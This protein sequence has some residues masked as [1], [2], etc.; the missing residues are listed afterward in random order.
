MSEVQVSVQKVVARFV[1]FNKHS[2]ST[3]NFYLTVCG[4]GVWKEYVER[5]AIFSRLV[6]RP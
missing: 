1:L 2:F 4:K 5:D 3:V 6:Q